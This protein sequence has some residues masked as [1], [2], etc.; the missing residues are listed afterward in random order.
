MLESYTVRRYLCRYNAKSDNRV[1]AA[2]AHSLYQN[3]FT[4]EQ[5]AQTL[6]AQLNTQREINLWPGDETLLR[7]SELAKV[8]SGGRAALAKEVLILLER[9]AGTQFQNTDFQVEHILPGQ[10]LTDGWKSHLGYEAEAIHTRYRNT[11]GNLLLLTDAEN[12]AASANNFDVKRGMYS[13]AERVLVRE[14]SGSQTWKEADIKAR[15]RRLNEI[16]LQLWKRDF[17]GL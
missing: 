4:G 16:A 3:Q 10:A 1:F 6:Y 17:A 13:Q 15:T 2:I 5:L 11:I 9:Q 7:D 12:R 8:Y 14:V